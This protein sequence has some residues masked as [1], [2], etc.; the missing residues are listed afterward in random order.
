MQTSYFRCTFNRL[1]YKCEATTSSDARS[2]AQ[3]RWGLSDENAERMEIT[4]QGPVVVS[5]ADDPLVS[6]GMIP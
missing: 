1:I 5:H 2:K 3:S 6:E 4:E